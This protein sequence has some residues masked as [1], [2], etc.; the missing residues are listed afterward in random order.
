MATQQG[1]DGNDSMAAQ[2]RDGL[3]MLRDVGHG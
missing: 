1:W 2:Q 3:K